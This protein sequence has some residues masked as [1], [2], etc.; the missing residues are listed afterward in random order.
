MVLIYVH[1]VQL[2]EDLWKPNSS[3]IARITSLPLHRCELVKTSFHQKPIGQIPLIT[4]P[5]PYVVC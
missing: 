1:C 2:F 3:F 5:N 4:K